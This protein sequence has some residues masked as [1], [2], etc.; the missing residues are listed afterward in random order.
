MM[1][2][3]KERDSVRGRGAIRGREIMALILAALM[4]AAC[5]GKKGQPP[6][7]PTAAAPGID[8]SAASSF[9][10]ASWAE[11]K[12]AHEK[13]VSVAGGNSYAHVTYQP[14]VKVIDK[15]AVDAS[16]QGISSDGHGAV[17][18][19]ASAEIRALKA[20]DVMFV[21]NGFAAKILAA[22]TEGTQTVLIT[23]QAKL[24]DVVKQGEI[25]LEPSIS[26]NGPKTTKVSAPARTQF[27]WMDW[28]AAP[29]YAQAAATPAPSLPAG[30]VY[31][32]AVKNA[33]QALTS[34]WKITSWSVT[35]ADNVAAISAGLTK[36]TNGFKAAIQMDGT[37]TNFQFVSNITIPMPHNTI[38][39]GVSHM[40]GHMHFVW[41]IGKGT[42][43]V[44]AA[45]DRLKLP[46]AISIP[47]GPVL[48]G[49][50]LTLEISAAFLIH[51][52]LT[53]GNE[54]SKGGF[55]IDW[56]GT[57]SEMAK[58]FADQLDPS[59]T[60]G[61]TFAITDDANLSPVAPNGMVVSFCAPRVE[62]KLGL[63]GSYGDSTVLKTAATVID[64]TVQTVASKL[65]PASLYNTLAAS[66]LGKM[67]ATN[68]LGSNADVFA[69]VIHTQGVTHS[70]NLSLAPCT[71]IE[72]KVTGQVG[73]E[74]QLFNLTNGASKTVD[75]FTKTYTEWR[76]GSNFCKSV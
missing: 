55:T 56:V 26:F 20:G 14:E 53:G 32:S 52:A 65:L 60:V 27:G 8:T 63:L 61:L 57:Q 42:P 68:T 19:N 59:G 25:K 47:L 1:V 28:I 48:D 54:Y 24:V 72:L 12:A 45:E 66:P 35:P 6:A 30:N 58:T 5:G 16:I 67:S 21:K 64:H 13:N 50:P 17:F 36:D 46:A 51:P 40:S 43:G 22:Q 31:T 39:S 71:K 9:G 7:P 38:S 2:A 49:M 10:D 34:G 3:K 37:I 62:L 15:A 18:E 33:T 11:Q 74:M 70:S 73:G 44:W 29:A 41:E 23:D 76:P 75:T 4:L 69:Q